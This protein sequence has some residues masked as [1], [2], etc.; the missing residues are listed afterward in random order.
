MNNK[1]AVLSN[2]NIALYLRSYALMG[3]FLLMCIAFAVASP[4]FLTMSN[5]IGVFR[6]I[7]TN[8][9]LA[10]GMTLVI[11][12]GG[13]DLSIGPLAAIAGVVSAMI[14][15]KNP[16]LFIPAVLSGI[17]AAAIMSMWTGFLVAK[18]RIAPFI[19]SLSTMSIAKGI[20]LLIA[21][22]VPHTISNESYIKLGNGYLWDPN[23][24]GGLSIPTPVL[25]IF[26]VAIV[27]G[28]ILY[29]TK[30]GRHIY[31]VGGNENAAIASGINAARVKFCTYVLN[32]LLCGIAGIVLAGRITSGQPTAATG[33]EMDAITAVIVGGTSMTGGVGK[34]GGTIIGALIIGVLNNGLILMG[35]SSYYQQIIKG[36]IIAV[37]VLLDMKTKKN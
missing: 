9:I 37:A 11:I 27:I 8:G 25:V 1:K 10:I 29:K 2:E 4:T 34:I 21:D 14:L 36:I 3:I 26:I 28:I 18:M 6:Q 31:A 22:G 5:I 17:V 23:K 7:S 13:I 32:G 33:Y 24:T 12:T 30:Y 20:A 19:A 35:V 15:E 16:D